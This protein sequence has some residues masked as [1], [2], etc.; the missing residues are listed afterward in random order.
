[1]KRI[2]SICIIGT[3]Y[4]AYNH[5]LSFKNL[6]SGKI[7]IVTRKIIKKNLLKFNSKKV[8]IVENLKNIPKA[9]DAFIICS[10][11]LKNDYYFNY[12]KNEKRPILFE[13]PLGVFNKK[14]LKIKKFK[15]N[16]Y[17]SLNRRHYAIIRY[18]KSYIKKNN[19]EDVNFN[20][21]EN[22]QAFKKKYKVS[23]KKIFLFS[24]IHNIDLL[25]YL[26]GNPLR[27][28]KIKSFLNSH[29]KFG[30]YIFYYKLF[31]IKVTFINNFPEN[32]SLTIRLKNKESVIL[33]HN[34]NLKIFKKISIFKKKNNK[35]YKPLL[36]KNL[37]ENS[38]YKFGFYQQAKFFLKN[39]LD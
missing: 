13:K 24:T 9:V 31:I 27:V 35:Y 30:F 12:F 11:W 6:I 10:Y 23:A 34:N 17:I 14:F 32:S 20:I 28:R 21:C 7:Y 3:G 4:A 38:K 15:K 2:N 29:N 25:I 26:F 37:E 33:S 8:I 36:K 39:R 19:V 16:K 5:Y 1:M 18:L 22:I